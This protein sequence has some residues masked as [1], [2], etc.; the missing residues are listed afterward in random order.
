MIFWFETIGNNPSHNRI[1]CWIASH[2]SNSKIGLYVS[3]ANFRH[4]VGI[5]MCKSDI[6]PQS[7]WLLHDD[8][9]LAPKDKLN[10]K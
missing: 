4:W 5:S 8:A 7:D 2:K 3:V 6:I 1:G 10:D 9:F